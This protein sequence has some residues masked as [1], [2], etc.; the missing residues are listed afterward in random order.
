MRTRK[1][2]EQLARVGGSE[3]ANVCRERIEELEQNWRYC[4]YK[5]GNSTGGEESSLDAEDLAALK[6]ENG[7]DDEKLKGML[8]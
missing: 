5:L 2:F 3:Q 1:A 7:A 6:G 4:T 8:S